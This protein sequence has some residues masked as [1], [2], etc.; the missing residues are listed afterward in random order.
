M[1]LPG[2][3][4]RRDLL[5]LIG[6]AG[7]S[8]VAG[9][10]GDAQAADTLVEQA[11]ARNDAAVRTL[12]PA[13]VTDPA[14]SWLGGVPDQ[15]GLHWAGPAGGAIET[16]AA[17]FLHPQSRY[18][19]DAALLDRLRM[20][21][22][23]LVRS[24][25]PD[26]NIDLP[27]TNFNSPP[28]TGFVVH[29][30]ATAAAIG[31]RY[32]VEEIVRILRPFLVK[33]GAGM[34]AGGVHTPNHRWVISSALAQ[35]GD[36]F[37]DPRYLARIDQW[38]TEGID[39][40]ADGQFTERSTLVYNI[41][42]DRALVVM[43][44]KLRRPALLEPVRRNL[45]ALMYLIHA[46]GEVVTEISRRQDQYTRGGIGGYWFPLTYVAVTDQD[47]QLAA[48]ARQSA[49]GARLS[50]LME[51]AELSTR[52]PVSQPLPSSYDKTFTEVGIARVRRGP[53][54]ATIVLGGSSRMFTFRYGDAVLEGVRV[55]TSFF[56]K[57]QFIPDAAAREGESYLLRQSLEAPYYQPLAR[58]IPPHAWGTTRP[59]RR[60]SEVNRLE[61]SATI[62]E[63]PNGFRLR[64][65]AGGTSGVPLA[66]E[67]ACRDGGQIEGCRPI[68][69]SPGTY[70]LDHGM[71][72]YRS[73]RHA[74]RFGPGGAPH[75]Y[76]QLRGAEPRLSGLTV[77]ITGITPFD[78]TL[79]FEGL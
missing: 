27:T 57:G 43:A 67:I 35:V 12:L 24:Q 15:F 28:D 78:Q 33:A 7:V 14:S 6:A 2:H 21:A 55:A 3:L 26:G 76:V 39:I 29:G 23:F 48:M 40:D 9:V 72:I 16:F 69:G 1:A 17:S 36:L 31:R 59:E 25:S 42:C 30:V 13:Q 18:H 47:G 52:M 34:A 32:G 61:Q 38:L 53:L 4:T 41:V 62:T 70:L 50:A 77:Y 73:G 54:S 56:G 37:P 44:A 68:E 22:A 51:Y 64:V 49:D 5:T 74:I 66:I 10:R 46:D 60:Q 71:G 58:A 45:R 20:A 79:T 11:V 19:A 8:R 75:R 65:L 63:V